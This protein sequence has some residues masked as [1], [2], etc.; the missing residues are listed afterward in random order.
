M[1]ARPPPPGGFLLLNPFRCKQSH[2]V[3]IA[4]SFVGLFRGSRSNARLVGH[5]WYPHRCISYL[6]NS[7]G[8][9][10]ER[11][12]G[13]RFWSGTAALALSESTFVIPFLSCRRL[14]GVAATWPRKAASHCSQRTMTPHDTLRCIRSCGRPQFC[15][16]G[17]PDALSILVRPSGHL[18]LHSPPSAAFL[19]RFRVRQLSALIYVRSLPVLSFPPPSPFSRLEP[20]TVDWQVSCT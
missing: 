2:S 4:Q 9:A 16:K 6:S 17:Q 8:G 11:R 12:K 15:C 13:M 20:N 7:D 14:S 5:A 10:A 1:E 19:P 3:H 18:F